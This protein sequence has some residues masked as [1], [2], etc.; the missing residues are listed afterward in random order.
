MHAKLW[1]TPTRDQGTVADIK[2]KL[3]HLFL[4]EDW[5]ALGRVGAKNNHPRASP[6]P[7]S[8]FAI[9]SPASVARLTGAFA[10]VGAGTFE[11]RPLAGSVS[12]SPRQ[13]FC[14][15]SNDKYNGCRGACLMADHCQPK[16]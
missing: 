13:D 16:G 9:P 1:W 15:G 7:L 11:M 8:P 10:G 3:D 12:R 14:R 6:P 2:A 4:L 5:D